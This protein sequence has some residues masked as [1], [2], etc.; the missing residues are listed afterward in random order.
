MRLFIALELPIFL[1]DILSSMDWSILI[2]FEKQ[3][4]DEDTNKTNNKTFTHNFFA[5]IIKRYEYHHT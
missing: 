2:V 3:K 4:K 5:K 1:L